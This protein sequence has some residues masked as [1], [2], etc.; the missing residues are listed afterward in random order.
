MIKEK[1]KT[2]LRKLFPD[3]TIVL[4]ATDGTKTIASS[5][6]IFKKWLDPH[7]TDMN[8]LQA[9]TGETALEIY[10]MT[11][12][13]DFRKM[14]KSLSNDLSRLYLTQHQIA[15][16]C[17]IHKDRLDSDWATFFLFKEEGEEFVA[18]VSSFLDGVRI[19]LLRLDFRFVWF[20]SGR[21][22]LVVPSKWNKS[23][24]TI[25]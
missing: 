4:E 23:I 18:F 3:E 14:F 10:E 6:A 9:P 7:F 21:H 15:D 25:N 5:K 17:L 24:V 2:V 20:G 8:V 1:E 22:R 13:A 16:Y 11:E 19:H 12:D